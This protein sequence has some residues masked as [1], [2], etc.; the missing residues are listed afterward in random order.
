MMTHWQGV[1]FDNGSYVD[2]PPGTDPLI[3]DVYKKVQAATFS[4]W[5]TANKAIRDLTP[6]VLDQAF[7]IP[8]PSPQYYNFWQPWVKNHYGENQT[9]FRKFNWIDQALKQ[10]LGH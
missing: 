9:Y 2:T 10:S 4:D 3:E 1:N 8:R 5:P 6:Y 7:Y